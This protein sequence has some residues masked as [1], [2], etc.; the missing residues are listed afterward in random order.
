MVTVINRCCTS[1]QPNVNRTVQRRKNTCPNFVPT[2]NTPR[3]RLSK[4]CHLV[5][6]DHLL[7][8]RQDATTG[9]N[10]IAQSDAPG[11]IVQLNILTFYNFA[12]S[13]HYCTQHYLGSIPR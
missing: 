11:L 5:A 10:P 9:Q 13:V 2:T 4:A 6:L 1:P 8:L 7:L 12:E 3:V